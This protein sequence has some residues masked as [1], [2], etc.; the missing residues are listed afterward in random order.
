MAATLDSGWGK[1]LTFDH[2]ESSLSRC[3]TYCPEGVRFFF[4]V[5]VGAAPF[6]DVLGADAEAARR[7]IHRRRQRPVDQRRAPPADC[8]R[9]HVLG[10]GP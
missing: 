7:G 6:L 8:R 9:F 2:V 4:S 10:G 5:I 3:V 1:E